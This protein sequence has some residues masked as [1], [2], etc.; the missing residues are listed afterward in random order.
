M[1][2]LDAASALKMIDDY[3]GMLS[4]YHLRAVADGVENR[5]ANS[6]ELARAYARSQDLLEALAGLVRAQRCHFFQ[7]RGRD[8]WED[9]N[10]CTKCGHDLR[11]DV[12]ILAH[13]GDANAVMRKALAMAD[14]VLA[15]IEA[16]E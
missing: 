10:T 4:P 7:P 12:H 3:E 13:E 6:E 9:R 11:E 2:K 15:E 5:N 1:A 8:T 16:A 14:A